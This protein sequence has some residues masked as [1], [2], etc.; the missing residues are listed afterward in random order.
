M[1]ACGA[2]LLAYE[3][4]KQ[5]GGDEVAEAGE[6]PLLLRGQRRRHLLLRLLLAVDLPIEMLES[7]A[8]L[9]TWEI[10]LRLGVIS[11]GSGEEIQQRRRGRGRTDVRPRR[12]WQVQRAGVVA[13]E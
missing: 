11:N 8:T 2:E 5:G 12:R 10:Q 13:A 7:I 9:R 1:P 4:E 6:L 3:V